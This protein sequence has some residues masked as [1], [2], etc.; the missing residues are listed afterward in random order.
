MNRIN[1]AQHSNKIRT[2]HSDNALELL[3][4][5]KV[6]KNMGIALTILSTYR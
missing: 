3:S 6:L 1:R 4:L 5:K 2:F